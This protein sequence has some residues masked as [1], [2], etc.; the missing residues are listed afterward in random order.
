MV[1]KILKE[2]KVRI[3]S[4]HTSLCY[5]TT[6][7]VLTFHEKTEV[8]ELVPTEINLCVRTDDGASFF[9]SRQDAII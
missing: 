4:I 2:L 1:E 8:K 5:R 7:V 6:N 9:N 3:K